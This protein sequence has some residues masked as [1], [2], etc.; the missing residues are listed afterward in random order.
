MAVYL[1]MTIEGSQK[2]TEAPV[3]DD[4]ATN[5]FTELS[6]TENAK[7]M[8]LVE[9]QSQELASYVQ[10]LLLEMETKFKGMSDTMLTRIDDM[11]ARI[12]DLEGQID[13][14]IKHANN[15]NQRVEQTFQEAV[16]KYKLQIDD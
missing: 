5:G 4:S 15:E 7:L 6:P 11:A 10:S 2:S 9:E 8:S 13:D 14:M 3:V 1:C 12:E 16:E